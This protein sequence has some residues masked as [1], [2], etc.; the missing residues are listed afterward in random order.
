MPAQWKTARNF[1]KW[2]ILKVASFSQTNLGLTRPKHH[3]QFH[4]PMSVHKF[5]FFTFITSYPTSFKSLMYRFVVYIYISYTT[6]RTF[7]FMCFFSGF[8]QPL[9]RSPR[10]FP[11]GA[12][13]KEP[14]IQGI[15]RSPP[16]VLC[17]PGHC[18]VHRGFG[19]KQHIASASGGSID[20]VGP[21]KDAGK[22][23][24]IARWKGMGMQKKIM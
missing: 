8:C 19:E 3:I 17:G 20:M 11:P 12:V 4:S 7:L 22:H 9:K 18:T 24:S 10:V 15:S 23:S 14:G 21:L 5:P 6:I 16:L 2:W 13:V 1:H